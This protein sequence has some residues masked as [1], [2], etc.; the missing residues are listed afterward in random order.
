MTAHPLYTKP[1]GPKVSEMERLPT[2]NFSQ[3][4]RRLT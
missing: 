1:Q 4:H 3:N 2:I